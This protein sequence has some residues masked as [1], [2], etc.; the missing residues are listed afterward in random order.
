MNTT[1]SNSPTPIIDELP[2]K[3]S[4]HAPRSFWI[5]IIAI[6]LNL[7]LEIVLVVTISTGIIKGWDAIAAYVYGLMA[8]SAITLMGFISSTIY[9]IKAGNLKGLIIWFANLFVVGFPLSI[10]YAIGNL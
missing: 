10:L 6:G 8:I 3:E 9:W 5:T 2:K 1:D 7:L 4:F